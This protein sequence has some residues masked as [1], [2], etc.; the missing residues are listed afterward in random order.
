MVNGL[1]ARVCNSCGILKPV[2]KLV[3]KLDC[4]GGYSP[5]CKDCK[6]KRQKEYRNN[7]SNKSTKIYEKSLHGYLVRTYRNMLSRVTGIQEKKAHLYKGLDIMDKKDFYEWSLCSN[8]P[9]L[10][11]KYKI[12][13]YDMKLAPSIDRKDPTRGYVLDNIRWVT[14]SEN[15]SNIRRP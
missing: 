6:N 10:L 12:S 7:N 11:E 9:I 8:Y 4:K 3:K 13:N 1:E 14:H 15:S 2:D 5:K